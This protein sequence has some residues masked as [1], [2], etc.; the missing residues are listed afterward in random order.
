M[1]GF[2]AGLLSAIVF[3]ILAFLNIII[4]ET[5]R[6]GLLGFL[7]GGLVGIMLGIVLAVVV[8]VLS[9][10]GGLIGGVITR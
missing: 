2:G 8:T 10:I 7:F 9:T 6:Y 3:V 4:L 1:A 5:V